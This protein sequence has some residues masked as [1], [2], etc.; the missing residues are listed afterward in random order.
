VHKLTVASVLMILLTL[1]AG[2]VGL[3]QVLTIG[4][5]IGD[6][7]QKEQQLVW[8]LQLVGA[9]DR[10]VAA[11]D[12]MFLTQDSYLMSTDVP[13]SLGVLKYYMETL[14]KAGGETEVSDLLGEMQVAYSE[15]R[16]AVREVDV[17]AR[18][19]LWTEVGVELEREV[20][21]ANERMGRLTR[22][23]VHQA[24]KDVEAMAAR[25]QV[26]VRRAALLLAVLMVLTTAIALGW[27]QFVFR[28][29]SL[30]IS[31]LR[32]GVARISSGD[33]EQ[34]GRRTG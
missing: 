2:G 34:D 20:G 32:Q 9:G 25:T 26:V 13:V 7:R 10:L 19:E 17:L 31:E 16:Q 1:L 24:D 18:Q 30:S 6:A 14:Q 27:R 11:L 28:G 3:W 4:Q 22:R 15:L 8:S 12:H 33:L 5:V 23:L 29:L 21:P